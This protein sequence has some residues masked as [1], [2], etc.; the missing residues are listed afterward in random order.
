VEE[1]H[2]IGK[3]KKKVLIIGSVIS[4]I[5]ISLFGYLQILDSKFLKLPPHW[6]A[7]A[8]LPVLI[9]LFVGGFI[10]RFKGFGVELEAALQAPVT[11]Q[12]LIVADSV[13]DIPGDEKGSLLYLSKLPDEKKHAIRRLLFRSGR[14]NYYTPNGIVNYIQQLPNLEYF[15]IR[16]ESGEFIC[17][18]PVSSFRNQPFPPQPVPLNHDNIELLANA[19]QNDDVPVSFKESAITLKVSNDQSLVNVLKIMRIENVELAAAIS[20]DGMY[21]GVIFATDIERQIANSVLATTDL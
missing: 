1:R 6:I 12:N 3:S 20:T 16:K 19:I 17:F 8:I 14:Q 21:S 10:T 7:I 11:S 18:L 13:A 9:S 2:M 5:F 4:I 15:D